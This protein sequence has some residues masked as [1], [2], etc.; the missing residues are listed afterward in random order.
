MDGETNYP[1]DSLEENDAKY[2][3]FENRVLPAFGAPGILDEYERYLNLESDQ[4]KALS[5]EKCAIISLR[6]A[7]YGFYLQRCINRDNS[8]IKFLENEVRRTIAA[9]V[10]QYSGPWEFQTQQAI[11][12]NEF[13]ARSQASKVHLEQRVERLNKLAYSIKEIS[14]KF[15]DLQFAKRTSNG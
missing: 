10:S 1:K 11:N 4:I 13:A 14:D 15:K 12:D 8:R 3:D 6:L 7:Q 5:I 2:Q 9:R